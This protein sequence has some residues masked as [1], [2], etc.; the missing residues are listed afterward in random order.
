ML[1]AASAASSAHAQNNSLG[2][3]VTA[4]SEFVANYQP[5]QRMTIFAGR[6]AILLARTSQRCQ[7]SNTEI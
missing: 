5:Q 4:C 7:R 2:Y 3:G 6:L 1:T